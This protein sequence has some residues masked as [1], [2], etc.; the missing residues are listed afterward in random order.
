M[1]GPGFLVGDLASRLV[2]TSG[3]EVSD[4]RDKVFGLLGLVK[5]AETGS[6]QAD[7]SLMV[8][9]VFIGV[10]ARLMMKLGHRHILEYAY[11]EKHRGLRSRFGIPSWVPFWNHNAAMPRM[12][13]SATQ[14]Q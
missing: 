6:L 13:D 10:A 1:I 5:D 9:E 2:A 14:S 3:C 7:Y 12:E 11:N 8:R 4:L